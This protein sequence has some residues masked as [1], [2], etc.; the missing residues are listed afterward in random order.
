MSTNDGQNLLEPG[1][2]PQDNVQFM[3][4]LCAILKA[5]DEYADLLRVSAASTGNDH[6]LGANEAPPAIISVFLGE[7]L[8]DLMN[9]IEAGGKSVSRKL[10]TILNLGTNSL[11]TLPKDATDRNRTSPFAFT[12]NKFEFRMVGSMQSI[13]QV[14]YVLN[15]IVAESLCLFADRLEKTKD[16]KSEIS[17]IILETVKKHKRVVFNGNNYAEE[18]I[19]EAE[20]R[21]LP[22]IRNTVDAIGV[23]REK[24][25]IAVMSKH[26]VLSKVEM[27]SRSEIQYEIYIKTINIEAQTMIEMSKRQI[28][29]AVIAYK[30]D[31]ADSISSVLAADGNAGVEKSLFAAISKNLEFFNANLAKLEKAVEKAA[32]MHGNTKAQA[33]AYRDLVFTAMAN[34]RKDA[35]TLETMVDSDYWPMPTYSKLL[36]NV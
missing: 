16:V 22:N 20:K 4:F 2:T 34:L 12:G 29:P 21:G 17:A 32:G 10:A 28:L 23:I 18:W 19:A 7:Q 25:N 26:G 31:M 36:F 30:A 11:P 14:N 33:V 3:L 27:E 5:I 35:D 1:S 13:A 8:T 15:T 6:R 9:Q 24:K